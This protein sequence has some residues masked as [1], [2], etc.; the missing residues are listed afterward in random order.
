MIHEIIVN[1]LSH[2]III[3]GLVG[4]VVMTIGATY[5]LVEFCKCIFYHGFQ[6]FGNTLDNIRVDLGRSIIFGIDFLVIA[7][8]LGTIIKQDYWDVGILAILVL[9]RTTLTYFLSKE[10]EMITQTEARQS[11]RKK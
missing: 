3:Y 11:K 9:I 1:V 4:V 5:S 10:L 7:D 6:D 8:L 2:M